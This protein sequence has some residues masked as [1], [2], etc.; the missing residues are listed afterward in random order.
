MLAYMQERFMLVHM[1]A[2]TYLASPSVHTQVRSH[3]HP[4]LMLRLSTL[5]QATILPPNP[6]I[7]RQ[8]SGLLHGEISYSL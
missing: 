4:H 1:G 8:T 6:H 7:H 3:T 5:F 2:H